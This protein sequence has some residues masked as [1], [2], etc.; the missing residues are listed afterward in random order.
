MKNIAR[1]SLFFILFFLSI[2]S[3]CRNP[4][5]IKIPTKTPTP[6]VTPSPTPCPSIELPP[7]PT[8]IVGLR[9]TLYIVLFDPEEAETINIRRNEP[10]NLNDAIINTLKIFVQGEDRVVLIK[11]GCRYYDNCN[12]INYHLPA[13]PSGEAIPPSP[14]AVPSFTPMPTPTQLEGATIFR[15]TEVA[16]SAT[17]TATVI[18]QTETAIAGQNLCADSAWKAL[19][20]EES[21]RAEATQSAFQN[22]M[23]D[24]LGNQVN[25]GFT[26]NVSSTPY[27]N[28]AVFD[29]LSHASFVLNQERINFQRYVIL[30]FDTMEDWRLDLEDSTIQNLSFSDD[31]DLQDAE[32]FMVMPD[33]KTT[34]DPK[35]C[36]T[37]SRVWDEILKT[38]FGAKSVVPISNSQV[39]VDVKQALFP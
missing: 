16:R 25:S 28:D 33:C 11:M 2:L 31:I 37:R 38:N 21:E 30:I 3:G 1:K 19:Y 24:E 13:P 39:L 9:N 27:A 17:Q 26:T 18:A 7:A 23:K 34:Y 12:I 20:L 6:S 10:V 29:S 22:E 35:Y 15:E 36:D 4:N 14:T 32:I 8:S 5:N